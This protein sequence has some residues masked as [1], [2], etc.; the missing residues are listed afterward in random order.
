VSARR[1]KG[2]GI[3][4]CPMLTVSPFLAFQ[5]IPANVRDNDVSACN[6]VVNIRNQGVGV[7][8]GYVCVYHELS[9]RINN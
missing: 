2:M 1:C 7:H 6:I 8:N 5:H 3:T 9:L 4:Y